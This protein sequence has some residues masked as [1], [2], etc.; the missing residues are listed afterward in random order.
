MDTKS[1]K[2]KLLILLFLSI[3]CSFFILGFYNT[4]NAYDAQ[5]N[6]IEQKELDLSKQTSKFINS[7]LQSKIDIVEAVAD[8][9]PQD[10]LNISNKRIVEKL[11]LAK[12]AGNF[13]DLYLG[14]EN[15]GDFLLSDGTYLNITKDNFDARSRPWYKRA[16]LTQKSGV[17]KPYVDITTKKL[18]VT[19][20]TPLIQNNKLIGVVG[21][22]IFL[23]TVV[24]TI[25]NV[26]IGNDGFAYLVSADGT[27][28][29]HKDKDLIDKKSDYFSQVKTQED[30]A[31]GEASLDGIVKLIS[32]SKIDVT[33][34]NLVVQLDK[35]TIFEKINNDVIKEVVL[36]VIL[37]IIILLILFISLLKILKPL[38]TL[39]N[40]LYSFFSYLKGEEKDVTKL[41]I[42]TNDEFG[43]MAAV[44]DTQIELVAHSFEQDRLLIDDVTNVVNRIK[45]GKLDYHVQKTTTNKSLNELK[46]I[47]NEM[48][49]T[50]GKNVDKDINTILASIN[51]YS[52]LNFVNNIANPTGNISN[53]LNKLSDIINNMLLENKQNGLSLDESS[54]VLLH[55]VDILNKSSNDT[56]V[57][58][59]ETAAA[60][61]EITSTIVNN[62][63]RIA[64]MAQHS[65]DLS[66]SISQ[67][68]KLAT[69]TV[70]SMDEINEQTQAIADAIT[71]IDQIAFQ[72]NILSLNAAVEAATAGEAGKG[73]AVVAQEV[74]NLA[75][76]SAEAAK[77]IKDLVENATNK[78]N[79]GKKI[80]DD[81]IKGYITLNKNLNKTTEVIK[82]IE[83]ASR[84]QKISIEQIN[85]VVN[86]LD[87]Q[88][89]N[90]ASVATQTHDIAINT[91][92]IAQKILDTVN[93]KE[94]RGK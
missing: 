89:Q 86:R 85:D 30:S 57:S 65:Q 44:I 40:G 70:I 6:L 23:D 35:E 46:N 25:L 84:E 26:K 21:S 75:S 45:E 2:S 19:V 14:F 55:N 60:V 68:Q 11:L 22:D 79:T 28:F 1:I 36:Y 77:E 32:Y 82:D 90:N 64:N 15:N 52:N 43:K 7:Y 87:Q 24:D 62:T 17:T 29:I 33:N 38:K 37:L 4:K 51:E 16:V 34:W 56:A 74:R 39:E 8:E 66:S 61:E 91:S 94:F 42:T 54:K 78:T 10:E 47:L 59:E 41:N 53:G 12:K 31:F 73:F 18:V 20:F 69:T 72:T 81:M 83:D 13:V 76:R 88:T 5:Y 67:G 92:N 3:S 49:E 58:L 48:I 63:N 9:L 80:A 27:I 71:V 93:E 50:I